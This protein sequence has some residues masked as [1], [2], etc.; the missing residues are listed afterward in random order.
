MRIFLPRSLTETG[1]INLMITLQKYLWCKKSA[2]CLMVAY[3]EGGTACVV[4]QEG[5][6]I[7]G[8]LD[9]GYD[10]EGWV[11]GPPGPHVYRSDC[12]R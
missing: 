12:D 7:P 9:T 8:V 5:S 11:R 4:L 2:K 1:G 10:K 6:A 3:R